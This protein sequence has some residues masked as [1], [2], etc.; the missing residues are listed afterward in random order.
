MFFGSALTG[1]GIESLKAGI[2][3]CCPQPPEIRRA[4]LGPVFK[5]ER[6]AE[7]GRVAYVRMFSGAPHGC[8]T[9]RCRRAR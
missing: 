5:I 2:A 8:A 3:G 6:D 9:V 1:A 4:R 7:G